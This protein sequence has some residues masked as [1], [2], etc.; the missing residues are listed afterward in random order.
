M[1]AEMNVREG[2]ESLHQNI[3]FD[4]NNVRWEQ[5]QQQMVN[6]LVP[7][8]QISLFSKMSCIYIMC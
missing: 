8:R 2:R 4:Q 5:Q 6:L 1:A 7:P 3:V